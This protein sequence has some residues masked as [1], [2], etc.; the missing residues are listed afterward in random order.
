M[1]SKRRRSLAAVAIL[2]LMVAT[3]L[4]LRGLFPAPGAPTSTSAQSR[5]TTLIVHM[6]GLLLIVPPKQAGGATDVLMPP[7]DSGDDHLARMVFEGRPAR[8]DLCTNHSG[9]ECYVDMSVW[10]LDPIG[11]G[12]TLPSTNMSGLPGAVL[13]LTRGSG[14]RYRVDMSKHQDHII[15]TLITGRAAGRPCSL[16]LWYYDPPKLLNADAG[17]VANRLDWQIQLP[18]DRIELVFH[19]RADSTDI[20]RVPLI[21]TSDTMEILIYQLPKR[22]STGRPGIGERPAHF[23]ALYDPLEVPEG[24]PDRTQP[25]FFF[26]IRANACPAKVKTRLTEAAAAVN[27]ALG[28]ERVWALDT[29]SCLLAAAERK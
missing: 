6:T 24:D 23:D 29:F 2:V 25:R 1:S 16:G 20:V 21:A 7:P 17:P 26:P 28:R 5:G 8:A 19:R 3:A 18:T 14:N 10:S 11:A 4:L 22:P 27:G 12:G 15:S 9:R 13:D